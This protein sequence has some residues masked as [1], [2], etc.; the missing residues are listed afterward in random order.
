MKLEH[1]NLTVRDLERS[2]DFYRSLLGGRLRWRGQNS[3][4]RAAAHVGTETS[5]LAMFQASENTI[6]EPLPKLD[7][8]A[9]GYNHLGFVVEDMDAVIGRL[10][11]LGVEPKSDEKYDPGRHV[12]FIDPDGVE[13]ELVEY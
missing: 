12:Y 8:A 3:A 2:I 10:R 5:Y 1:V 6:S 9:P 11:A 7:S 13:V 4:G